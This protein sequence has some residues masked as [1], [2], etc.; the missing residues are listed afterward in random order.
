MDHTCAAWLL[1]TSAVPA[2]P[3]AD[4]TY[5]GLPQSASAAPVTCPDACATPRSRTAPWPGPPPR[6]W[7]A[8]SVSS[9]ICSQ[10]VGCMTIHSGSTNADPRTPFIAL[11][12][13]TALLPDGGAARVHRDA[14]RG[15]DALH[16]VAAGRAA[17]QLPLRLDLDEQAT[18]APLMNVWTAARVLDQFVADRERRGDLLDRLVQG[19]ERERGLGLQSALSDT[20]RGRRGRALDRVPDHRSG[21]LPAE[22]QVLE[23]ERLEQLVDDARDDLR[24]RDR[25]AAGAGARCAG[26]LEQRALRQHRERA[27]VDRTGRPGRRRAPASL[28][29]L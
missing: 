21:R 13:C 15:Q 9:R 17:E 23:R 25:P 6:N 28:I 18:A 7:P 19:A 16:L 5:T 27:A 2:P 22:E 1:P 12:S 4:V 24:D 3:I 26:A 8:V 29:A 10:S 14:T 20:R 11:N